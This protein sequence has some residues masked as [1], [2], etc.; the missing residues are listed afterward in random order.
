MAL[1]ARGIC[2]AVFL[3]HVFSKW[4][5]NSGLFNSERWKD[6]AFIALLATLGI[7]LVYVAY[8]FGFR[9]KNR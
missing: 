1:G 3:Q 9:Q 6:Y 5:A 7:A 2:L 8:D 4:F